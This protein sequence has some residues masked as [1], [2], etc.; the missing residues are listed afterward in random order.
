MAAQPA[1]T[2]RVVGVQAIATTIALALGGAWAF[3][4]YRGLR[5]SEIARATE[6]KTAAEA[7]KASTDARV[8]ARDAE[9]LGHFTI[10]VEIDARVLTEVTLPAA[11]PTAHSAPVAVKRAW[12][13]VVKLSLRNSGAVSFRADL[14]KAQF[15]VSRLLAVDAVGHPQY[16]KQLPLRIAYPDAGPAAQ[17]QWAEVTPGAGT[18]GRPEVTFQAAT[19]VAEPGVYLIRFVISSGNAD[20]RVYTGSQF[21]TVGA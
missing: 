6:I 9:V 19:L 17:V 11:V 2:E 10:A 18:N 20:Q 21:V 14:G 8:A 5:Q 7:A 12:P 16:G 15:Y 1:W 4:T 3:W 13:L